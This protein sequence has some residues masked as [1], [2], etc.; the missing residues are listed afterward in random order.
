[1][2][3]RPIG[4]YSLQYS[5]LNYDNCFSIASNGIIQYLMYKFTWQITALVLKKHVVS[6]TILVVINHM[7][8]HIFPDFFLFS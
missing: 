6:R 3:V 7:Q 4:L 1:M 8:E 5:S 2:H